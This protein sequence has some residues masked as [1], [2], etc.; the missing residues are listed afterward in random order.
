MGTNIFQQWYNR[1]RSKP[2]TTNNKNT[3]TKANMNTP[4]R[5]MKDIQLG[6][7]DKVVINRPN[8]YYVAVKESFKEWLKKI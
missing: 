2:L 1:D 7:K 8:S 6:K 5:T 3:D 4:E